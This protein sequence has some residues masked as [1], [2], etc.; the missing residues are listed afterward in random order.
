[1]RKRAGHPM[2]MERGAVLCKSSASS[3]KPKSALKE[4][5]APEKKM[6][7]KKSCKVEMKECEEEDVAD[8]EAFNSGPQVSEYDLIIGS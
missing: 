7:M 3:A 8:E 4:E 2:M 1:M 5:A 6:K